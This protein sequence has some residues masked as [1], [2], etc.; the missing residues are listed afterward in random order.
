MEG[1]L[2]NRGG[3]QKVGCPPLIFSKRVG[4]PFSILTDISTKRIVYG[5]FLVVK[6]PKNGSKSTRHAN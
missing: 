5:Y 2:Y 1:G 3:L 6:K 4:G